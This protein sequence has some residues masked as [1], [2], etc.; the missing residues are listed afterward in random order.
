MKGNGIERVEIYIT[1]TSIILDQSENHVYQSLLKADLNQ[2]D[3]IDPIVKE[4]ID[5]A[6]SSSGILI[7][8]AI[9]LC[10]LISIIFGG[11]ISAMW[12]MINTA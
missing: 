4:K 1:D 6:T 3:Y 8:L 2:F 12:I 11:S 7:A 10:L 9:A 5:K